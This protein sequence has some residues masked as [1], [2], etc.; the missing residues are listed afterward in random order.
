M[1]GGTPSGGD[2][3]IDALMAQLAGL[4]KDL[5][6]PGDAAPAATA[7]PAAPDSPGTPAATAPAPSGAGSE[8]TDSKDPT[9]RYRVTPKGFEVVAGQDA[10]VEPI[11]PDSKYYEAIYQEVAKQRPDLVAGLPKPTPRAPLAS[12]GVFAQPAAPAKPS[13][14]APAAKPV[15]APA[16]SSP[17]SPF[18]AP[19]AAPAWGNMADKDRG[20]NAAKPE[21]PRSTA[22]P[23][24]PPGEQFNRAMIDPAF[25]KNRE[26]TVPD[27]NAPIN[28]G[29]RRAFYER[30]VTDQAEVARRQ[31]QYEDVLRGLS[32]EGVNAHVTSPVGLLQWALRYSPEGQL[33]INEAAAR[34]AA[35]RGDET[36]ALELLGPWLDAVES[37]QV[38]LPDKPNN[39]TF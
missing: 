34:Q 17:A 28:A 5:P 15:A 2:P 20:A 16:S 10:D 19:V 25:A 30:Q 37:G 23:L 26:G 31:S 3:E 21:V 22:P 13:P 6:K 9:Y 4:V 36:R 12:A 1:P 32:A 33:Y 29:D 27:A 39:T 7:Q 38:K 8:V 24:P 35:G 11:N 14:A 18:A